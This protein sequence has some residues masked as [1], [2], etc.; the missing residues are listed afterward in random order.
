VSVVG[1]VFC[2]AYQRHRAPVGL[3]FCHALLMA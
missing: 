3:G 1:L 2:L